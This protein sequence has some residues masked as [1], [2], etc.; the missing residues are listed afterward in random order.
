MKRSRI[1]IAGI[2]ETPPARRSS[3]QL[4]TQAIDCILEAL[5]D[6]GI[7][8]SEVDGIVTDSGIVPALVPHDYVA[9]QLGI[10]LDFS[11]T[12]S[13]GGAGIVAAPM[14][15]EMAILS[16]RAKV[17]VSYFGID[18]GSD[19]DGP[20]AFHDRYPG[21]HLYEKPHGFDAQPIYFAHLARRYMHE[22]G[23][24]EEQLGSVAVTLRRNAILK[25]N[26]QANTPLDIDSYLASRMIA[27][28]LR[29]A[30][31]CLISDGTGAF[32]MTSQERARDARKPPVFVNGVGFAAGA[33]SG[34][35]AFTQNPDY[36]STPGA[37]RAAKNAFKDAGLVASDVDFAQIYDCF[38]ISCL[39]E[40]EDIGLAPR[41][42]AV[43]LFTS[44]AA[45][46]SGS[47]PVNTHGGLL[48]YSYRL[49]IEHIVEAVRQ[50]RGEA[51]PT[52]LTDPRIG[53]VSGYS[54]PD[55]A[56]L[57]LGKEASPR[58]RYAV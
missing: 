27:D 34:D 51:G 46:L 30:D 32:V 58:P 24:T 17:V 37:A 14:L 8:P 16:G 50:L 25:G 41:G 3:V 13:Y 40:L 26:A 20:Y 31:C 6:A 57:L 49:G 36:L 42:Q 44:G 9:G 52:Q 33:I 21:K 48:S 55:Y 28:P 38:T 35:S 1:A 22:Y 7:D 5:S 15:A 23:L 11:A 18:W 43:E 2:A 4:K 12:L 10:E 54:I 56:V 53:L 29:A 45:S 19:A 47:L 39:M